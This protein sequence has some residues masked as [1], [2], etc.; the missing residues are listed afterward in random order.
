ML[1]SNYKRGSLERKICN[2]YGNGAVKD[3]SG[4]AVNDAY[5]SFSLAASHTC[6]VFENHFNSQDGVGMGEAM[7]IFFD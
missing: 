3:Y 7:H 6:H 1:G 5:G 2:Y 4:G